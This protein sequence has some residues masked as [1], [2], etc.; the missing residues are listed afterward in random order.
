MVVFF[1][2][3][4]VVVYFIETCR[5]VGRFDRRSGF[6]PVLRIH[7]IL[8][9]IRIRIR[10]SM[11][12]TNGSGFRTGPGSVSVFLSGILN[13]FWRKI[14]KKITVRPFFAQIQQVIK[15]A[16]IYFDFKKSCK[17]AHPNS[18]FPLIYTFLSGTFFITAS[19]FSPAVFQR[20]CEISNFFMQNQNIGCSLCSALL[21]G[22]TNWTK[23]TYGTWQFN[24][25]WMIPTICYLT[26]FTVLLHGT[27]YY[28]VILEILFLEHT[29]GT[30]W[31][32][33]VHICR[34]CAVPWLHNVLTY[35]GRFL[36]RYTLCMK[37]LVCM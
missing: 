36:W 22:T 30:F 3:W 1:R 12:L 2:G 15:G 10:G 20:I 23:T 28:W 7:E 11:P 21:T 18:D 33:T 6:W 25:G 32:G 9:W 24:S 17:R 8:V 26:I 29:V 16:E 5:L 34:Y 4:N 31:Q 14:S 27:M 13:A 19:P 35:V 37:Y